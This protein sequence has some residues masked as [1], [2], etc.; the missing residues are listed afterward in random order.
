M[1]LLTFL[2]QIIQVVHATDET[3]VL[4]TAKTYLDH[5]RECPR[6]GSGSTVLIVGAHPDE[7]PRFQI[8]FPD[9]QIFY[10]NFSYQ[11]DGDLWGLDGDFQSGNPTNH[12]FANFNDPQALQTVSGAASGLFSQI[13]FD[14]GVIGY[15]NWTVANC[16]NLLR[17]LASGGSLYFDWQVKT[18][19]SFRCLSQGN[20][21]PSGF[22]PTAD[23]LFT[24]F[25]NT[26]DGDRL[27]PA[28]IQEE[29][30]FI[31]YYS[32]LNKE[33]T[34]GHQCEGSC[35]KREEKFNEFKRFQ[36]AT[37]EAFYEL[38]PQL[39]QLKLPDGFTVTKH[40]GIYPFELSEEQQRNDTPS[41]LLQ[42]TRRNSAAAQA[43][44]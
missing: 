8:A 37:E 7:A 24:K 33:G 1:F 22:S 41:L 40:A 43:A 6:T 35:V 13:W 36:E 23:E 16:S 3:A 18:A 5:L 31:F 27:I 26:L 34:V 39:L 32:C 4:V 38:A 21:D 29:M 19:T 17:T 30:T 20:E 28:E 25:R 11:K 15:T 42:I 12:I 44:D 9:K 10:W 2:T 14:K